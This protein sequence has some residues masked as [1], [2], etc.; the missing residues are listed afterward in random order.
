MIW[1]VFPSQWV[2]VLTSPPIWG[3]IIVVCV[4]MSSMYTSVGVCTVCVSTCRGWRLTLDV[5]LNSS[6]PFIE[7]ESGTW[8]LAGQWVLGVLQCLMHLPAPRTV[9]IDHPSQT[10]TC[11]VVTKTQ[12]LKP[13]TDWA[14]F[15]SS[16]GLIVEAAQDRVLRWEIFSNLYDLYIFHPCLKLLKIWKSLISVYNTNSQKAKC[17]LLV[18]RQDPG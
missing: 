16:W 1:S 10:F 2:C 15:P 12:K 3:H 5:L 13:D 11:V 17:D 9:V 8:K 14:H 6:P 7:T 18:I 4:H